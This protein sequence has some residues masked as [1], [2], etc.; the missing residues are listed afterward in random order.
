MK[1][2]DFIIWLLTLLMPITA[3]A[4]TLSIEPFTIGAGEEKE[5]V[6]DLSNSD[7]QVTALM[8][9]LRLPTGL[10]LKQANGEYDFDI[11]G[12]TTWKKHSLDCN[13][14]D[15]IIRFLMSSSSNNVLE[16]TSGAII[17]MTL[18]ASSSF[19]GG[20]IRLENIEIVDPNENASRPSDVT[21]TIPA[22]TPTPKLVLSAS[23]SG[24]QVS[25]GTTVTLTAKADGSTVYGCD[26][27][28]TTNG[29][30]PSKSN[31]T[32]YTSSG[33]A[34]TENCTLKAIAYKSGYEDSEVKEWEYKIKNEIID[35]TGIDVYPSAKTIKV[36]DTFIATYSL[37]PSNATTTVTW[38]SDN[39]NIASVDS[40]TGK[41]SGKSDGTTYINATTANGKKDW[42]KVTVEPSSKPKLV[43]SAT[44]SGGQ[45]SAGT[46]VTLTAKADGST[47]SGCDI[48]YT[49]NGNT[50]TKSSTKYNSSGITIN[51]ACT[52]KAIAYKNG[53][54]DS[55][56]LTA[57]FT[58]R[59][60]N[61]FD[62]MTIEGVPVTYYIIS[63]Q[64]KTCQ[65]GGNWIHAIPESTTGKLT[66]P[67]S[68]NGYSVIKIAER[69][70]AMSKIES[71]FIPKT[72]TD[73][74]YN[75]EPFLGCAKLANITV[76]AGN[77]YYDSR[78]GCNAIIETSTNKLIIGGK[79]TTI[80]N[81][82]VAIGYNAFGSRE[83]RD[84]TIPNSVKTIEAT[85]FSS[86]TLQSITI[87]N[88][89]TKI[90]NNAFGYTRLSTIA[91]PASV[92]EIESNLFVGCTSLKKIVV[93]ANNSVYD[94]RNNCNAIIATASNTLICGCES[95]IIPNT[96]VDIR[97]SAFLNHYIPVITIPNSVR[98]IGESAF[99]GCRPKTII[100]KIE[101]PFKI[102][103][104]VFYY[105]LFSSHNPYNESTLIVPSGMKS[106]YDS[107][108]GWNKFKKIVESCKIVLTASPSGGEVQKGTIVRL[109]ANVD[110][111]EIYYAL[112]DDDSYHKYS[113][114]NGILISES[115][116]LYASAHKEGFEDSD[117]IAIDYK[118]KE[119]I[120][121]SATPSGGNVENG[122]KVFLKTQNTTGC[123]IYYTLDG[124]MPTKSSTKYT[125]AGIT[126][127]E[128]CTLKAIGYKEDYETSDVLTVT[129]TVAENS[130]CADVLAGVDGNVY[131]V[132]GTV[133]SI[134]N[135]VYGNW[136]LKDATGEIFIY[137]TRDQSGNTGQNNS[138]EAWGIET[139]DIITVE[140]P[141]N[142]YN[143]LVELVDVNVIS[144]QKATEGIQ[145]T[146]ADGHHVAG[147][148]TFYSSVS[149]YTLPNG[150]LAQVVTGATNNKLTY[151]TIA[152]GSASGVIPK[153]TAVM[154][155]SDK[156]QAGTFTLTSSESTATYN[157][158]NLLRGSDEATT[159]TGNGS[160]YKLSYGPSGTQWSDVFGWYWGAQNGAPFQIEG[161]KAWLVVPNTNSS[162]AAGFTIDGDATELEVIE[163]EVSTM[164]HYYDLQGRRV[165]H[166]PTRKGVY[167]K[168]GK[169][170]IV[171]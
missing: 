2:A 163:Q 65:V 28:Y 126:I 76:E 90:G 113:S 155:V 4:A 40:S 52:L 158:T 123:E 103:E 97:N 53:Y 59:N 150:L 164:D 42:C 63:E 18:Q 154:L 170:M 55:D 160:H 34:I 39:S 49:T 98:A 12:R 31:G 124:T 35:P 17:K 62:A 115:V 145:V 134:T 51:S 111:A 23:P 119:K 44:P 77:N 94:S 66:I 106:L 46:T 64:D 169:K 117:V 143:G 56:V 58:T 89:V 5:M 41:V 1:K 156:K 71:I 162:R 139:D 161:H 142:T 120:I 38:S 16:G 148:A 146:F 7:M 99:V 10:S 122:T 129:Y 130:T 13:P 128:S 32:K 102:E 140:G 75:G 125:S 43:L 127:N 149:A 112:G 54:E 57:S 166:Q 74:R 108:E 61:T 93:D 82:V 118:V 50:P 138:I 88:S 100:S 14:I 19:A 151:K 15:G 21:Y 73:I 168:N 105:S 20:T 27:Y 101:A 157:S 48:Y 132:I 121:L 37:T 165:N 60:G 69:A 92:K 87:P 159:T 136:Y 70:F 116:K 147:Y 80:P 91:I 171:K 104:K 135:T 107:T 9:D 11:A 72:I 45:V 3:G 141:R 22:P 133:K 6:I 131:R 68:V 96:I 30:T 137:G 29:T 84:V 47:V 81:T 109:T 153:G 78:Q 36:G 79:N 86:S 33:I 25:A 24:G 67:S 144:L 83:I 152:D 8:F 167:I 110:D 85:A 114:E 26:I 95:T